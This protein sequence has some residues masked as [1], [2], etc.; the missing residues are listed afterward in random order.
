MN[1]LVERLR[2][3]TLVWIHDDG[4][5]TW[6]A[7]HIAMTEAA[8]EIER[9]EKVITALKEQLAACQ[10]ERDELKQA[11]E[12][13]M[14]EVDLM[15]LQLSEYASTRSTWDRVL[16]ENLAVAQALCRADELENGK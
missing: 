12:F 2:R 5:E 7:P 6:E 13:V 10:K 15:R 8:D 11:Q 14:T 3:G 4:T 9:L 16:Q 1:D